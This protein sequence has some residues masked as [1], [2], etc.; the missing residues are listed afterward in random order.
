[1]CPMHK[2]TC[3]SGFETLYDSGITENLNCHIKYEGFI[4]EKKFETKKWILKTW[5]VFQ[6]VIKSYFNN[7]LKRTNITRQKTAKT[8]SCPYLGRK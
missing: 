4:T 6:C 8:G 7:A 3:F 5:N 1:M 2:I